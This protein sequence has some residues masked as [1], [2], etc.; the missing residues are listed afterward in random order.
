MIATSTASD[1]PKYDP[2]T[3]SWDEAWPSAAATCG[4][5]EGAL[6]VV[7]TGLGS[8]VGF[9]MEQRARGRRYSPSFAAAL[10]RSARALRT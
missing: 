4:A 10:A 3:A 5:A 7:V 1:R 8:V 9:G 2:G 6:G